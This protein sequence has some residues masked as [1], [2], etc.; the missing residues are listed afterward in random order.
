[1]QRASLRA[2]ASDDGEL[3]GDA[4]E[5][6]AFRARARRAQATS[7]ALPSSPDCWG[8]RAYVAELESES[9]EDNDNDDGSSEGG[10]DGEDEYGF[11]LPPG[12]ITQ[13]TQQNTFKWTRIMDGLT[14]GLLTQVWEIHSAESGEEGTARE[15]ENLLSMDD[16]KQLLDSLQM[17]DE[18]LFAAVTQ[19]VEESDGNLRVPAA[20]AR[21]Q[22]CCGPAAQG[23]SDPVGNTFCVACWGMLVGEEGLGLGFPTGNDTQKKDNDA[24]SDGGPR[25]PVDP[26]SDLTFLE[27]IDVQELLEL[28]GEGDTRPEVV[29]SAIIADGHASVIPSMTQPSAPCNGYP[30]DDED[31]SAL[32]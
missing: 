11:K 2:A 12:W 28:L 9:D 14:V 30:D 7:A 19:S 32:D 5:R 8:P 24:A 6:L 22:Y 31:L 1:M 18:A 16:L 17:S 15:E 27:E 25:G 20:A 29:A 26:D 4:V 3:P 21:C 10:A 23:T 13:R